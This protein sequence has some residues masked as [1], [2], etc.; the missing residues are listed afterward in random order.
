[1]VKIL[2]TA[3]WQLGKAISGAGKQSHIFREQLFLTAE[4]IVTEIAP[5]NDADLIVVCGD[6]FDRPE[7]SWELIERTAEMLK[8]SEIPIH[9][10]SGSTSVVIA[11]ANRINIPLEYVL[12]GI[13]K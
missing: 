5:E 7:A 12:S 13:D 3:D 11:N 10:I 6:L 8:K 9:I 2:A 4:R 1:M